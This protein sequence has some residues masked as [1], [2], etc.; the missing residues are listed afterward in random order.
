MPRRSDKVNAE[1]LQVVH[2]A[3]QAY[4][5][6]LATVARAGID[7]A[8][9]EK[10]APTTTASAPSQLTNWANKSKPFN[11][12]RPTA[13]PYGTP[14]AIEPGIIGNRR[15]RRAVGECAFDHH[16]AAGDVKEIAIPNTA[17]KI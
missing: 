1:A 7:F 2:G 8:D 4:N 6:D 5:F 3:V 14:A 10:L 9:T 12:V 11:F 17:T 16:H 13:D 15:H